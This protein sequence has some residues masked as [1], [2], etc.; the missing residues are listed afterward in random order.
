MK[1]TDLHMTIHRVIIL[2]GPSKWRFFFLFS[3]GS[4]TMVGETICM[5]RRIDKNLFVARRWG[6]RRWFFAWIDTMKMTKCTKSVSSSYLFAFLSMVSVIYFSLA[7][8]IICTSPL[9]AG[10][11]KIK[12]RGHLH[13]A[14]R[15]NFLCTVSSLRRFASLSGWWDHGLRHLI[16]K[17]SSVSQKSWMQ[18]LYRI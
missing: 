15:P 11:I 16:F 4:K 2:R 3:T 18:Q 5:P 7:L 9:H 13:L 17:H 8:T 14:G 1:C 12:R 10:L 6:L